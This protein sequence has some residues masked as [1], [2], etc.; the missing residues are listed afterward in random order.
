MGVTFKL[1]R[2][3][4]TEWT[5]QNPI[6][7]D[8]EPGVE[9]D[10]GLLKIG[11]GSTPWN[12]LSYSVGGGDGTYGPGPEG[13]EGP[14]G[15]AGPPGI[16]GP[17]GLTGPSGTIGPTGPE[18]PEGPSGPAGVT[19]PRGFKGDTGDTGP[20]GPTGAEGPIGPQG[21]EGPMGPQGP[22]GEGGAGEGV[23][24]PTGPQGPEGPIGPTGPVGPEGPAGADGSIGL[25]GPEGPAGVAGA[26]G[27]AGATGPAGAIGPTG[28]QGPEGPAGAT[29]VTG[30]K[31]DTGNTGATGPTGSTG[32]KGDTGDTGPQGLQG[33]QGIQGPTGPKGD[34]GDTGPQGATG[35]S[36]VGPSLVTV[37]PGTPFDGQ[38]IL[39]QNAAMATNGILWPLVY[40]AG[41]A[42]AYKWYAAG[43][44]PWFND[45]ITSETKGAT[46]TTYS[47]L[48]TVGPQITLPLAGDYF[49]DIG[50]TGNDNADGRDPIMS[51]AIGATAAADADSISHDNVGALPRFQVS[52]RPN[53]K[54]AL[55][56]GTALV[57]KYRSNSASGAPIFTKR[58]MRVT[59]IRVG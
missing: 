51:Y 30:P 31:G 9:K 39:Y 5:D 35:P 21:A 14:Q 33:I 7:A 28:A 3:L 15:P 58:W 49:V 44:T 40:V 54:N 55:A 56:S 48:A 47:D 26:T 8:G 19:G 45:V 22:A 50:F 46:V 2:G 20:A 41:A 59:P 18:G 32:L 12:D 25:Q 42:G 38:M 37:L 23:P 34:T 36:G 53:R 57:A 1:K 27:S 52:M 29:G 24:G 11:D 17:R 4:S 6:L 13:P 10:T 43:P 16:Q